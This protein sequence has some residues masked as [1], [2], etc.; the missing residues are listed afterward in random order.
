M[1]L[2]IF[3]A[4]VTFIGCM[5]MLSHL[6]QTK[7]RRIVGYKGYADCVLHGSILL[8]FIGT[9]TMGL[10]QAEAAGICISI[11]LRLYSKFIGFE[12][13]NRKTKRWERTF[14]VL[15]NVTKGAKS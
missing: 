5:L 9:S 14:G 11:Y 7:M 12:R 3:A 8:L 4:L 1:L 2:I 15:H 13:F 6:G 10:L